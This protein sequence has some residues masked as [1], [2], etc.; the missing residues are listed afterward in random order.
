MVWKGKN[1]TKHIYYIFFYCSLFLA[2]NSPVFDLIELKFTQ[3]LVHST[4]QNPNIIKK[5]KIV[6][7]FYCSIFSYCPPIV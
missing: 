4:V 5:V 7:C 3:M 6:K 1:E 2:Y